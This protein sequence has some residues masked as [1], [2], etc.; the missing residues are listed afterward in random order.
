MPSAKRAVT[1]TVEN[2]V[3]P[4]LGGQILPDSVK[5]ARYKGLDGDVGLNSS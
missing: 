3:H 1:E 2:R 5:S 4:M